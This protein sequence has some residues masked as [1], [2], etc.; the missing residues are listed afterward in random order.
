MNFAQ[1]F[2]L[3]SL[4]KWLNTKYLRSG[5]AL[6]RIMTK[7]LLLAKQWT[8]LTALQS[9]AKE[10]AAS[11][12]SS[13]SFSILMVFWLLVKREG[14]SFAGWSQ[15]WTAEH[16]ILPPCAT[17]NSWLLARAV[18]KG[19]ATTTAGGT[20]SNERQHWTHLCRDKTHGCEQ[21]AE[22]LQC[23]MKLKICLPQ[24]AIKDHKLDTTAELK[25]KKKTKEKGV[26]LCSLPTAIDSTSFWLLAQRLS[27][28]ID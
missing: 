5:N 23:A 21:T 9:K 12:W 28:Y 25:K 27:T 8:G 7:P 22:T 20:G 6:K 11:Y 19:S 24:L 10:W 13:V 16:S 2:P 18:A 15:G 4:S 3:L 26:H 17:A 14:P 1:L